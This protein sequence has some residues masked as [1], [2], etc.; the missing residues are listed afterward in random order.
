[1]S[2]KRTSLTSLRAELAQRSIQRNRSLLRQNIRK[3]RNNVGRLSESA[4]EQIDAPLHFLK[5][6]LHI[7]KHLSEHPR[8]TLL[9]GLVLGFSAA[10][11]FLTSKNAPRRLE[12]EYFPER[13]QDI[14]PPSSPPSSLGHTLAEEMGKTAACFIENIFD[15]FRTEVRKISDLEKTKTYHDGHHGEWH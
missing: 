6:S 10:K 13:K 4:Q 5:E 9:G 11:S 12:P 8:M 2:E 15:R 1:M 14:P 7:R 3:A